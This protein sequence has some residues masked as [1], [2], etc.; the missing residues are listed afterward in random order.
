[1]RVSTQ[2]PAGAASKRARARASRTSATDLMATPAEQL[3]SGKTRGFFEFEPIAPME[4]LPMGAVGVAVGS[5]GR[6]ALFAYLNQPKVVARLEAEGFERAGQGHRTPGTSAASLGW[7]RRA[8]RPC[9]ARS[10]ASS[11][12]G[13]RPTASRRSS[14]G[15]GG[16]VTPAAGLRHARLWGRRG[17]SAAERRPRGA[18]AYREWA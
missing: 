15:G 4:G 2:P 11:V 16:F 5:K 9:A 6:A 12:R 14:A 17:A 13:S 7:S 1:M 8:R 3:W 18:H 10:P